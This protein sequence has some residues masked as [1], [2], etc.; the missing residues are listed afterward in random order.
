[1]K[2]IFLLM[3]PMALMLG[4][5]QDDEN[6]EPDKRDDYLVQLTCDKDTPD[7]LP[8]RQSFDKLSMFIGHPLRDGKP[9]PESELRSQYLG[10]FH[11]KASGQWT[12]CN[13]YDEDRS[14]TFGSNGYLELFCDHPDTAPIE[15]IVW[16]PASVNGP[17][18]ID[19]SLGCT[20]TVDAP[21]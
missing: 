2:T 19:T 12:P 8:Q 14:T 13:G 18:N 10:A 9:V 6:P 16:V 1:M 4:C 11:Y 7:Y 3:L 15:L 20:P 21:K 17:E 5:G